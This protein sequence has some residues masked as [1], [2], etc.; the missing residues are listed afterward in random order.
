MTPYDLGYDAACRGVGMGE[1]PFDPGSFDNEQWDYGWCD[2]NMDEG[3][4]E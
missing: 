2:A 3:D 4:D 1:N